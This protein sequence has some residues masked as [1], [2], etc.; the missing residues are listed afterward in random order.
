MS[1]AIV[2]NVP[3]HCMWQT[4]ALTAARIDK[5]AMQPVAKLLWTVVCCAHC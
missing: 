4:N 1:W 2:M 3:A 5:M